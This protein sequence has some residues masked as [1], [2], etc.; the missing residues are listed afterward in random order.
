[1]NDSTHASLGIDEKNSQQA[2]VVDAQ[3][4]FSPAEFKTVVTASSIGTMVEWYDF[5]IYGTAS[6]LV[7][8]KIFFRY[9][10]FL[11]TIAAFGT[12]AVGLLARPFG[13]AFFWTFWG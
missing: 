3:A 7:F 2:S 12:A 8:N 4:E 5:T 1:M 13:G 6:A 9:R 10:S 11:G